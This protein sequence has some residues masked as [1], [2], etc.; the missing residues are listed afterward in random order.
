[1]L[2]DSTPEQ[3]SIFK[4]PTFYTSL[5]IVIAAL[6]VSWILISRHLEN[7]QIE[8]RIQEQRTEKQREQDRIAIDQLGGNELGI[9]QFY[10]SPGVIRR[11]ESAQL[12]YGVSNARTITLQPQNQSLRPSHNNCIDVSPQKTTTYILTIADAAGNT[13][14]QEVKINVQ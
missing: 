10:A 1:M 12:C 2:T 4:H 3:K 13:K 14:S 7:R 8:Q 9:Q 11:G 6:A 5:A